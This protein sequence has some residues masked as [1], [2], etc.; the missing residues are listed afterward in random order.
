MA[1]GVTADPWSAPGNDPWQSGARGEGATVDAVVNEPNS[2]ANAQ[3]QH[4]DGDLQWGNLE[5]REMASGAIVVETTAARGARA[6]RLLRPIA[7]LQMVRGDPGRRRGTP[8]ILNGMVVGGIGG[9]ML[10]LT[11]GVTVGTFRDYTSEDF[12]LTPDGTILDYLYNGSELG[13]SA[14]S[15]LRQVAAW[16]KMTKLSLGQRALVLYQNLQGSAWVN[17]ESLDVNSLASNDGVD[18]FKDW[19][20]QHYLDVEVTQ[21]GRS[22][23]DLFRK[24][25]RKPTQTFRDYTAEFNRLLARVVECG[26]KLPDVANAWLYVDRASL[27]ETTEVSLLAS[28]GNKYALRE[29]QQAAIV[30]DR[31]MRKPWEKGG[32]GEV[33]GG[34]RYNSDTGE[35]YISYMTAKARY[36]DAAKSRG[37]VEAGNKGGGRG[38]DSSAVKKAAEGKILLAKAKSHCAACGQRGHWHKDPECPKRQGGDKPQTVHVTNEIYELST[39]GDPEALYAILDS[40][41]SKTVVGTAWLERYLSS[42]RGKGYETDFV[43]EKEC[44]KFGAANKIYESTYAAVVMMNCLGKWVA[45][46]AAVVHGDLPLLLSRP[47]LGCLGLVLDLGSN[48]AS[49]RKLGE[50]ELALIETSGGHPAILIDQ[51]LNSKPDVSLLPKK[52]EA[53]GI[54]RLLS[55]VAEVWIDKSVHA[56]DG[57]P[58][59]WAN[60]RGLAVNPKWTCPELRTVLTADSEYHKETKTIPKG[61]T[62]MT[63]AEL[64]NEAEKLKIPL[65]TK[66]T[67]GSV[68]LKVRD[69]VTPDSTVMAIGRFRGTC[70]VDIP[71]NYAQWA[72]DEE[73]ENG[74]NMSPDLKRF[75]LWRRH[76]RTTEM[77]TKTPVRRGYRDPEKDAKVPPPPLSE[78]GSSAWAVVEDP[79]GENHDQRPFAPSASSGS[80]VHH[81]WMPFRTA[82][83][84]P[85][86]KATRR[87]RT[88]E[89]KER[90]EQDIDPD[91][92]SEIQALEARL[93]SLKEVF[94]SQKVL[95]RLSEDHV[96]ARH[97]NEHPGEV[98]ALRALTEQDFSFERIFEI[99]NL[100]DFT[101]CTSRRAAV[102]LQDGGDRVAL[103]YYAYGN[104]KG[105]CKST[106][107]WGNLVRYVNAFLAEHSGGGTDQ[108]RPTYWGAVTLLRNCPATV[109]T[110]KNNLKG[111]PNFVVSFGNGPSGGLWVESPGGGT[112]RRDQS[113]QEVEGIVLDTDRQV[114]EFDPRARHASEAGASGR[115]TIVAYTPR[116]FPDSNKTEKKILRDLGFPLP[117]AGLV[118]QAR[119]EHA[120]HDPNHHKQATEQAIGNNMKPR[121]S[122]R[123]A[124]WKT[125]AFLNVLFT[126]VL[127]TMGQAVGES[128]P[129]GHPPSVG[130]LEVGGF[131]A[132]CRVGEYCGDYVKVLEP[133]LTEDV[134]NNDLHPDLP[135]GKVEAAVIRHRPGQLWVHVR[136]EWKEPK[137]FSDIV[138]AAGRQLSEGRA[139]IFER[140]VSDDHLWENFVNGWNESGYSTSFD[141]DEEGNELVRVTYA[142][143]RQEPHEVMVG[144]VINEEDGDE[145][146]PAA[147]HPGDHQGNVLNERGAKA[148][149]FPA[150]VPGKIASSLRRLHQNLGHPSPIDFSRH[151]RLAGASR[152][153]LKAAKGLECEV[154]KRAK[155]PGIAKP[156]KV[157]PCLRFNQMIGVD[158]FYVHDS[159]GD[160]HQLLSIVDYSSAYHVVVPVLR[161]D[162][163]TLEKAYCE[164]WLNVFG[165]PTII[166]VDLENGLEKSLARVGDW[167]GTRIRN[168]AGQAHFQAGYTER[169]GGIWKAIFAKLCDELTVTKGDIL[170]AIGA[171]SSA[172]N[173][174]A[175]ISGYSPAQH[176]FGFLPNDPEDLLFGPH[177]MDPDQEAII[178]DRHAQEVAIRS[179]ARA[180]YYHV[181]TDER[182]RR[183]LSGRT[184]VVSRAPECGERV[185]YYR[186]TKNNKRGVWMGPGTVIGYEGVNAWVTRGGRCVLCAP[187]HLR[188]ATPEELGQAFCLRAAREDLDKLLNAEDEEEVF[189]EEEP[190]AGGIGD[191][192]VDEDEADEDHAMA[193]LAH[194]EPEADRHGVRRGPE[195]PP[196]V[197]L[198]RQRRK[199]RP[200]AQSVLMMKKAKT[201]RS[202]EKALEKEIPWALIPEEMRPSFR[203]AE[204]KQW[205]EHENNQ[206]ITVLSVAESERI[207]ATVPAERILN[208]R[209][210]YKDKHMGL[211]RVQ[212]DTPWKPKAR[213]VVGGHADPDVSSGNLTT[214]SPTVARSSLLTVLQ[215][216]ASKRWQLAAGDVQAAFLQGVELRRELWI[217]QPKGG[218][219]GLDPRQIAKVNKGIFGLIESPRMWYDRLSGVLTT[220][221][222]A[223][224]GN[225]YKL[226]Q[227]P[228]D[229]CVFMLLQEGEAKE[230]EALLTVH[231]DD[232]LIGAPAPLNK[233]LQTEISR[234]FPVDDWIE[235]AFEYTGSFIEV[236]EEGVTVSQA[237]FVD[238]RLFTVDVP[239]NQDGK[240]PAD[241]EQVI[242]NRSL[243]GALSWLSS[244]S[245][246][247]LACGV[248][249]SQQLQRAPSADDVRFVNRLTARAKEHREF[250]VY[251][252]RVPLHRA[253]FLAYHDAG[254]A[255]ADLEEAEDDFRLDPE[256]INTGAINDFYTDKPRQPKRA[257]SKVASQ[258]GHLIMLFPME[259]LDGEHARGSTLEWR[260]QSCKRVCR[261]T[262][263]AETMAAAEGLEGAQYMR[264]LLGTLLT[265]RLMGHA[266]ARQRWPIVCLSDCKS[267]FDF[268]HKTGVPKM[269]SDRR[270]AIDLAALR[271]ELRLERW[272]DRL[273]FQWIPTA[274]QLADPLTKPKRVEG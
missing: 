149:S 125:A 178:D 21:V 94:V 14:R 140:N 165:A 20:R 221:V 268:L 189:D 5:S 31:S 226:V 169:Q 136:H 25:R 1:S 233:F 239:R 83:W 89:S 265:G 34:R 273:P 96:G 15:Y 41:C 68:M 19:I 267:L 270:L 37:T 254:W 84:V 234:L 129:A 64:R 120:N 160:R 52:W 7:G 127:S 95:T 205:S 250:G 150:S 122:Q 36:R 199:G 131:S 259:V 42:I 45:V 75:V 263:G 109:H 110:D 203:A 114:W 128:V 229:P 216:S 247:D 29:L 271:Q 258:I 10:T 236:T 153:V 39:S 257:G 27:D 26:C 40:A 161:K 144:E 154:C 253:V 63:L 224:D 185:F 245:R 62:S 262:F 56:T 206:A 66:E 69:A 244:Q 225:T 55:N 138:E 152:E 48:C 186:K 141:R 190:D 222:F 30:L 184:R 274:T 242:D 35:L 202:R 145:L 90:M 104:F 147:E 231:V 228:L 59:L 135:F 126:T 215:V 103:G 266:E 70:Y 47:A 158:I 117:T 180:A 182:V 67:R 71:E 251:L 54:E 123:K 174:L 142:I 17:A 60:S 46:K 82:P 91:A 49:F 188:L 8:G 227:S 192:I 102:H 106:V 219:E 32:R 44:F 57:Y 148:I 50:G 6:M 72:S 112:W 133:I 198:K 134:M 38:F 269:P 16:E 88:P 2:E 172:K 74:D 181:Q 137:V 124:L 209:Y 12:D 99:L 240:S 157:A 208:T 132:T 116:T 176:V 252:R 92:L 76:R 195:D 194:G 105:I 170:P 3:T 218:V 200:D 93:A 119:L 53:H 24:L 77:A 143:Y 187:E 85:K 23:S 9:V 18:Y 111:S 207:R 58:V 197:V 238:G 101:T 78:T 212:P 191:M 243:L 261:S 214:D 167:T 175:R 13:T 86:A 113:G 230:P 107:R 217:S 210:A 164:N 159:G 204:G 115:W 156:A 183:A 220:E 249:L 235:G 81:N 162:T 248:A 28:V 177:A 97:H 260:S 108:G 146:I 73:K 166:A 211:R 237:S 223:Y 43:Y 139:V 171:V 4:G 232:I 264:A 98:A 22:L 130:M 155:A 87:P 213:L 168:A 11:G 151:L 272:S 118:R 246:P 163:S 79:T 179:A 241:E 256:E 65:A 100:Y 61:L 51:G 196:L 255:N 193:E 121:R 173:T 80:G 201:Q 33:A